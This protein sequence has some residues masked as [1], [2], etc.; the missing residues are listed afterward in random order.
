MT[1]AYVDRNFNR[2]QYTLSYSKYIK[3]VLYVYLFI[4]KQMF[5]VVVVAPT[6]CV[7]Y[8]EGFLVLN[9]MLQSIYFCS[10]TKKRNNAKD[11][12]ANVD[13]LKTL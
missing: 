1:V 12:W 11:P 4:Y 3:Y 9:Q 6:C 5:F 2:S 8:R 7:Q 13:N 10:Y